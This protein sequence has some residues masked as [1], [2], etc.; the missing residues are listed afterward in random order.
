MQIPFKEI[1]ENNGYYA[2]DYSSYETVRATWDAEKSAQPT[3]L[4]FGQIRDLFYD[5]VMAKEV[6]GPYHWER[7]REYA[8]ANISLS[9]INELVN[10]YN[11]AVLVGDTASIDKYGSRLQ[12][13]Q[14]Q[15]Q[16]IKE[17]YPKPTE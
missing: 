14:A 8:S 11:L 6:S 4:M 15:R 7:Q 3:P 12:Q 16:A 9:E 1:L 2:T 10:E 13:L 17:Q 5:A